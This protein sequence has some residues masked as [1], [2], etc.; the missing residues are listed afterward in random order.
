MKDA[1]PMLEKTKDEWCTPDLL[2]K[3]SRRPGLLKM[4]ENPKCMQ[5]ITEFQV[6]EHV[7]G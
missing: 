7:F 2:N 1:G 5:A 6:N 3:I 4:F